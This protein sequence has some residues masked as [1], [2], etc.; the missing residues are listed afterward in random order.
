MTQQEFTTKATELIKEMIN[1]IADKD[2]PRLVTSIPPKTT[3][4][5]YIDAEETAE[6]ACVGFGKW[7]GE[8][9]ALWEEDN[10]QKYVVD[11]FTPECL[12]G[13]DELHKGGISINTYNPTS[14]GEQLD[15]WFEI[16]FH[17]ENEQITAVFDI[18]I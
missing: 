3:W 15:F 5:K 16:E 17:V 18:N 4:A 10:E 13:I 6:N 9:L 12:D 2:F 14:F 7:L 8:Q 1:A 11:H